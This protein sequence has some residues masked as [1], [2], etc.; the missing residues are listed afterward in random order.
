MH[1]GP[2]GPRSSRTAL[3]LV[4][5]PVPTCRAVPLQVKAPSSSSAGSQ[6]GGQRRAPGR[7]AGT[8][9]VAPLPGFVVGSSPRVGFRRCRCLCHPWRLKRRAKAEHRR[10]VGTGETRQS[11]TARRKRER[12]VRGWSAPRD[13]CCR[14]QSLPLAHMADKFRLGRKQLLVTSA[15]CRAGPGVGRPHT[16]VTGTPPYTLL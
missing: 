1:T 7:E 16:S 9:C 6:A 14:G 2:R 3:C 15:Y 10:G 11:L 5:P 12:R 4:D 13:S 8:H